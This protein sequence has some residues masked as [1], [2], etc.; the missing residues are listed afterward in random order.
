[1]EDIEVGIDGDCGNDWSELR[2]EDKNVIYLLCFFIFFL[3]FGV[4]GGLEV[5]LNG[6]RMG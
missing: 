4:E 5:E 6:E 1:M 3:L 2:D